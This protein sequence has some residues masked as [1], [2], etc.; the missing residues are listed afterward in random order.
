MFVCRYC[1][2]K[3]ELKTAMQVY[4]RNIGDCNFYWVCPLCGAM[5]GCKKGTTKPMGELANARTRKLRIE[6]HRAFDPIW[7][8]NLMM[9]D[10]AYCWLAKH[11][12][13][14]FNTCHFSLMS[15]NNLI[16]TVQI[17]NNFLKEDDNE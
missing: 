2:H 16:K 17:C 14:T 3:P 10:Q 8:S 15:D 5:V 12:G 1:N 11:L 4:G 9:R 7:K 6:A 13:L